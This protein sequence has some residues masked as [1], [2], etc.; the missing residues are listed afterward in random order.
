MK[1]AVIIL[2]DPTHGGEEALGRL[3]NALATAADAKRAGD[4]VLVAF[5]GAGTRWPEELTKLGHPARAL[6][7][8]V[9]ECVIGASCGC[10]EV[11]GAKS[12]V[13]ACGVPLLTDNAVPGTPGLASL[14]GFAARGFTPL[15]F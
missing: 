8:S 5:A 1:L 4:D 9:R 12:G 10:S 7:E 2:S 6:Y 11:F 3:F 13:E 14:R 15:V